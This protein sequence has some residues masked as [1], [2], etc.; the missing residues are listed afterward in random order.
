MAGKKS[1]CQRNICRRVGG[2]DCSDA[3]L[4]RKIKQ[5]EKEKEKTSKEII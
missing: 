1:N 2:Y 3:R 4:H 5:E